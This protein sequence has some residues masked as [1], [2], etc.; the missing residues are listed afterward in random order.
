MKNT[1]F[2]YELILDLSGCD[3][4]S[5]RDEDTI[6]AFSNKLVSDIKM[7][8]HEPPKVLYFGEGKLSGLSLIQLI[9]T[10]NITAHFVDYDNSGYIN[11]FSCKEFDADVAEDVVKSFFAPSKIKK[12]FLIRNAE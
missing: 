11:I 10:S 4:I 3:P 9:T 1:I 7:T 12:V 8:Q 5:I 6:K 2:G